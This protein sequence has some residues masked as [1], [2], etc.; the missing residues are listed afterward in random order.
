MAW[1]E[2]DRVGSGGG[3]DGGSGGEG[4]S[5]RRGLPLLPPPPPPSSWDRC[6]MRHF[7]R[8]FLALTMTS[9]SGPAISDRGSVAGSLA[10]AAAALA[11]EATSTC[12]FDAGSVAT[13]SSVRSAVDGKGDS[14]EAFVGWLASRRTAAGSGEALRSAA[15]WSQLHSA[16][17][18]MS[19]KGRTRQLSEL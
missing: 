18:S 11:S 19:T 12:A 16:T 14:G 8:I 13:A 5:A 4:V 15:G 7:S 2:S 10:G 9:S 6:C 17:G 1:I 3:V